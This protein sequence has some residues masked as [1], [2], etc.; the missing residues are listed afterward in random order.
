MQDQPATRLEDRGDSLHER[1]QIHE[2]V[3]NSV[4]HEDEVE[5]ISIGFGVPRR[6]VGDDVVETDSRRQCEFEGVA[7]VLLR[8]IDDGHIGAEEGQRH[9]TT[10]T[11]TEEVGHGLSL[12]VAKVLP[13]L[14]HDVKRIGLHLC[15]RL[16]R[17]AVASIPRFVGT[18][19]PGD[20]VG[21][22]VFALRHG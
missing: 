14:P 16:L 5:A 21:L 13:R 12:Y 3:Q 15:R 19:G 8:D 6:D 17:G 20:P 22:A 11:R 7:L 4:L 18:M 9:G 2:V 1:T 10:T